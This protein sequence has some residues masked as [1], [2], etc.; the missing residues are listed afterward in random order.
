MVCTF[1]P[2]LC[3]Y[4]CEL[5]LILA[6]FHYVCYICKNRVQNMNQRLQQFLSAENISQAQFADSIE[7][8]R[9]SVSHVL[10][11]RNRPGYDFI[12]S[13]A[14]HYP[15]LNLEW[16]ITGKGKMYKLDSP[17]AVIPVPAAVEPAAA[18]TLFGD[19]SFGPEEKE[20]DILPPPV[21]AAPEAREAPS[22]EDLP[23]S[24]RSIARIIV[25]YDDN[26]YQELK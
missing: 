6:S 9:A 18:A 17:A 15:K 3:V 12:R 4:F 16:L 8:A 25:F 13:I 11:G 22:N 5:H 19:N 10:A 2:L 14:E 23:V 7:V 20:E 21:K 1:S 26:T 24:G